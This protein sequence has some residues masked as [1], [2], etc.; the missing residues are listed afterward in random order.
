M[1]DPYTVSV[2]VAIA[3]VLSLMLLVAL[4]AWV[5][6]LHHKETMKTLES[7]GDASQRLESLSQAR[8]EARER[9]RL[10]SGIM[11]GILVTAVGIGVLFDVLLRL[12]GASPGNRQMNPETQALMVGLAVFLLITGA[13][14][15]VAH[16]IWSQRSAA[17]AGMV[18][19]AEDRER[20]RVR[21]GI[22]K[23]SVVAAAGVGCLL[24]L[25]GGVY[26]GDRGSAG[27]LLGF[28]VFLLLSGAAMIAVHTKWF[29]KSE[30]G[31][32]SIAGGEK[33]VVHRSDQDAG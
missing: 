8:M 29:G 4:L 15:F 13:A 5:R 7:G 14:N 12:P 16:A 21:S 1:A 19:G 26:A 24:A 3:A 20:R 27:G 33:E 11:A 10:R 6:Y 9:W 30:R 17:T 31:R 23:G 28:G 22:V 32:P 2:A 25:L 18:E